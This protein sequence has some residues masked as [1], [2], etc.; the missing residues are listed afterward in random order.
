MAEYGSVKP[1]PHSLG[2]IGN[3]SVNRKPQID[4]WQ[5]A[6]KDSLG[7]GNFGD[8][9]KGGRQGHTYAVKICRKDVNIEAE[10]STL[11]MACMLV[12]PCTLNVFVGESYDTNKT[13]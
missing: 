13:S 3:T 5:F 1:K 4:G 8:V 2:Q 7:S 11:Y 10:A 9:W 6:D 12:T